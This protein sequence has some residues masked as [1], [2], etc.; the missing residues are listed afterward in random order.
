MHFILENTEKLRL[1][2]D[3]LSFCTV[4]WNNKGKLNNKEKFLMSDK[5]RVKDVKTVCSNA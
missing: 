3:I 2:E 5:S 1:C 4:K